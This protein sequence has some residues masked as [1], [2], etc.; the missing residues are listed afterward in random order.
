MERAASVVLTQSSVETTPIE[1]AQSLFRPREINNAAA[2]L[3]H[4]RKNNCPTEEGEGERE[5]RRGRGGEGGWMTEWQ[6][7]RRGSPHLLKRAP[8]SSTTELGSARLG[9]ARPGHR[10]TPGLFLVFACLMRRARAT[11]H[12][13]RARGVPAR[14]RRTKRSQPSSKNKSKGFLPVSTPDNRLA[15]SALLFTCCELL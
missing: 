10:L 6:L 11:D 12:A 1:E 4:S 15:S 8:T 9:S 3:R 5:G 14:I 13:P 2:S 7:L